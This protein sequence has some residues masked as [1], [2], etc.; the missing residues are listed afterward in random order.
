LVQ[1]VNL[2][3]S[4]PPLG[5]AGIRKVT[6]YRYI[7]EDFKGVLLLALIFNG[8]LAIPG[9]PPGNSRINQLS[10]WINCINGKLE[11]SKSTIFNLV[12]TITLITSLFLP[13]L[14]DAWLS[15]FTDAEGTFNINITKRDNTKTGFRIQL[16]YI[17][18]QKYAM[19]LL[20]LIK[21]LFNHGKVI[22][23]KE[24]MYRYY[25]DTFVGLKKAKLFSLLLSH[26]LLLFL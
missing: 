12:P 16:R 6:F 23:R 24:D 8:N 20:T 9:S 25:C 1:Y 18:D 11:N 4:R 14:T 26:I 21:N 17:L 3:L 5:G 22:L 19:E 13:T 2:L 10:K 15:G 7:V